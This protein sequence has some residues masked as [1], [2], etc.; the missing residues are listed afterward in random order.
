MEQEWFGKRERIAGNSSGWKFQEFQ[1]GFLGGGRESPGLS[2]SRGFFW[3]FWEFFG[4]FG[5]KIQAGAEHSQR[6][7]IENS[8]NSKGEKIPRGKNSKGENFKGKFQGEKIPGIPMCK[9]QKNS[10]RGKLQWKKVLK[11]KNSWNSKDGKKKPQ[12]CSKK[13]QIFPR[14]NLGMTHSSGLGRAPRVSA[15]I[16][17]SAHGI[18]SGIPGIPSPGSGIPS[19]S[20]GIPGKEQKKTRKR[21]S[22]TPEF[23]K[24][25]WILAKIPGFAWKFFQKLLG[26]FP[27]IP[28]NFPPNSHFFH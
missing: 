14:K 25:L 6:I 3:E 19:S 5:W 1:A 8:K 11:G 22:E 7:P 12:E 23:P 24:I 13:S 21:R 28:G 16:P 2:Q 17:G 18:C 9:F 4:N 15:D 26:I 27:K 10:K 20:S